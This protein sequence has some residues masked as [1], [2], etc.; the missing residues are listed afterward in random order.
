[1]AG[2][3]LLDQLFR[4]ELGL[5]IGANGPAGIGFEAGP[6]GRVAID[7]AAGGKEQEMGPLLHRE[8][9]AGLQQ[10]FQQG[11]IMVLFRAGILLRGGGQGT[12]G[13]VQHGIGLGERGG[14]DQLP[15]RPEAVFFP[16]GM[17]HD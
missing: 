2:G 15:E 9:D 8:C 6:A 12:P 14:L 3:G 13:Q 1:M 10:I 5:G 16:P 7:G 11:Q 17:E 4:G